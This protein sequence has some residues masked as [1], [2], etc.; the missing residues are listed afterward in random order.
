M[1]QFLTNTKVKIG[2]TEYSP[3]NGV[4]TVPDECDAIA[5]NRLGL[6]KSVTPHVADVAEDHE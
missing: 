2:E 1:S 5:I 4:I 3:E 6:T